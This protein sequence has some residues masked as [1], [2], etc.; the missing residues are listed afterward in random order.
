MADSASRSIQF[1]A[2]DRVPYPP[3]GLTA[4]ISAEM[5]RPDYHPDYDRGQVLVDRTAR[6]REPDLGYQRIQ[7]AL[8]KLGHRVGVSTIRRTLKRIYV[9]FALAVRTR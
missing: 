3:A 9:F 2:D 7:G 8:L 5:C 1:Y 6:P 4:G